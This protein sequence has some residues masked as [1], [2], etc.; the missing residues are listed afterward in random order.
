MY[1]LETTKS[2]K[3]ANRPSQV[4]NRAAGGA[5][6]ESQTF[7]LERH[8]WGFTEEADGIYGIWSD[9]IVTE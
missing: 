4:M 6:S 8:P 2:Q 1:S 3:F 5:F 9:I 7:H